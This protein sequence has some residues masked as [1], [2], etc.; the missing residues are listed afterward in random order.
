M[1]G[2]EKIKGQILKEAEQS[3]EEILAKA[4]EQA[5][6]LLSEADA[7]AGLQVETILKKSGEAA[8]KQAER[9][10]ASCEMLRR[11]TLLAAKQELISDVLKEAYQRILQLPDEEYFAMLCKMAGRYVRPGEGTIYFSDRDLKRMPKELEE[12]MGKIAA[13]KG[14]TL[15]FSREARKMDG[16]F[17]LAYGGIEENCTIRAIFD[18]RKEELSDKVREVLF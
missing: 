8:A 3:A 13:G 5:E 4:K 16:G 7:Q 1:S 11:T 2:L 15:T 17:V 10:K 9:T 14:G 18:S 6:A 12:E